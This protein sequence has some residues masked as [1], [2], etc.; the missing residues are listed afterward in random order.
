M[1]P[2]RISDR[3]GFN[4]PAAEKTRMKKLLPESQCN[5]YIYAVEVSDWIDKVTG[6]RLT[7]YCSTAELDYLLTESVDTEMQ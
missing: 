5:E 6:E 4:L 7:G 3:F 2:Y 1:E